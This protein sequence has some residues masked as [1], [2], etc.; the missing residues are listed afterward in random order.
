VEI[1]SIRTEG[2]RLA[3]AALSEFGGKGLF[4]AEIE[5][6]LLAQRIDLAVHSLK[7]LPARLPDDVCLAAFLERADP[8]DVFIGRAGEGLDD[9]PAGAVVG[10]SSLRRRVQLSSRRPDLRFAPIRGNVDTRLRKLRDGEYDGLIMARAGL[11]RLGLLS[12]DMAPLPEGA[13]L[14]PPGQGIIAVEIRRGDDPLARSLERIDH[15]DTHRE[16]QAERSFLARLGADCHSVVAG[17]AR[18]HGDSI[19]MTAWVSSVSGHTALTG[20]ASGTDD[21]SSVGARLADDLLGRGAAALLRGDDSTS[22]LD[23][24]RRPD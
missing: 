4:V 14:P 9:L 18:A 19:S 16:A 17:L 13:F 3:Q 11:A 21:P 24:N 1:V 6:A 15:R 20:S 8:H 12:P 2:D 23:G 10:T 5:Q 7:D 22:P